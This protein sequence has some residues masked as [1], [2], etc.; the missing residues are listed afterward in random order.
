MLNPYLPLSTQSRYS[1]GVAGYGLLLGVWSLIAALEIVGGGKL[2]SP[3]E[4]FLAIGDLYEQRGLIEATLASSTR[5]LVASGVTLVL[6]L[7]IGIWMGASPHVNAILG[8]IVDPLRSA[9]MVAL[10]TPM[11]YFIGVGESLKVWFLVVGSI[12]FLVPMVRDAIASQ[13]REVFITLEDLGATRFEAIRLGLLPMALPRI[14]DA[15]ITMV[16]IQWTYIT[17]AEMVNAESGLGRMILMS[18]K[19]SAMDE[20]FAGIF[21]I[22]A[23]ALAT[24]L[25]LTAIKRALFPWE[26][27]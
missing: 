7:P 1:L 9:P 18:K 15:G 8:P 4:V 25:A 11:V 14:W 21:V 23:V 2:P 19:L 17:V 10:L 16:S 12:V 13:P 27:E 24:V 22:L 20:V 26:T 6:G 5:I 3:W